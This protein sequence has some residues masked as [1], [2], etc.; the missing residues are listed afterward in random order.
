MI[1]RLVTV[2][3]LM[4]DVRPPNRNTSVAIVPAKSAVSM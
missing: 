2:I 1:P 4:S 3:R